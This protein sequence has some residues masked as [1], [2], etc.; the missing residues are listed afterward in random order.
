MFW[1]TF[2]CIHSYSHQK[3]EYKMHTYDAS[4]Y[5]WTFICVI[6]ITIIHHLVLLRWDLPLFW[7]NWPQF[8]KST[9]FH[10]L[11]KICFWRHF[12][13]YLVLYKFWPLCANAV[14]PIINALNIINFG[15]V[16][17]LIGLVCLSLLILFS[18]SM[19]FCSFSILE[20]RWPGQSA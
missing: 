2:K 1:L 7:N 8:F 15:F 11:T 4:N 18:F 9:L 10:I 17:C 19:T 12:F 16:T 5:C 13:S 20:S 14:D 3:Q 6:W